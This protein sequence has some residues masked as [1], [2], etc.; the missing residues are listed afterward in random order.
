MK[1]RVKLFGHPIHPMVIVVP[2]GSFIS[3]VILD[4][5]YFVASANP[6]L[7]LVAFWNIGIGIVGGLVAAVF[8]LIDWLAIPSRT[9]AKRI[10]L[11][12]AGTNVAM[13]L[14][15]TV[16]WLDRFTTAD[17]LPRARSSCSRL[18]RWPWRWWRAGLAASSLTVSASASMTARISTHRIR[19]R[20][21]RLAPVAPD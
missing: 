6:T 9:R 1:S 21:D 18:A 17:H 20:D 16:A 4:A 10:G 14:V 8:G 19:C 5:V 7:G 11:M 13:I 3:A 2:L 12:H 15:F